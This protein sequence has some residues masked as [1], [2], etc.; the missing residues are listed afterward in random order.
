MSFRG[1]PEVARLLDLRAHAEMNAFYI[2]PVV[3]AGNE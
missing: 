2:V 3:V 1:W